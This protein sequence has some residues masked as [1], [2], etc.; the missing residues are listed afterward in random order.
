MGRCPYCRKHV[1]YMTLRPHP[2]DLGG[3]ECPHCGK[4]IGLILDG[5][6]I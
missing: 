6:K 2:T 4:S 1:N 5:Q 3:F